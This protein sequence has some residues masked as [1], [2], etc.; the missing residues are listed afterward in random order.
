MPSAIRLRDSAV[1]SVDRAVSILQV[2]ARLGA[3]GVT[4][5]L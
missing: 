3:A 1:Q 5:S 2:L 4:E